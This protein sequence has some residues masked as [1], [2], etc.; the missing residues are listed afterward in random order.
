[1]N[2]S[3]LTLRRE[4]GHEDFKRAFQL[5]WDIY[6]EKIIVWGEFALPVFSED[7]RIAFQELVL[8]MWISYEIPHYGYDKRNNHAKSYPFIKKK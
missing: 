7:G 5:F 1:M 2:R 4:R 8:E 6:K 3:S